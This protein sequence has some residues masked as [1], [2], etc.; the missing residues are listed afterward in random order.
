[1]YNDYGPIEFDCTTC[2]A[3]PGIEEAI[4]IGKTSIGF[5]K[6]GEEVAYRSSALEICVD[7]WQ[8]HT[9]PKR[10]KIAFASLKYPDGSIGNYGYAG[11]DEWN[12]YPRSIRYAW[13]RKLIY[14]RVDF[15]ENLA[16]GDILVIRDILLYNKLIDFYTKNEKNEWEL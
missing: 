6:I 1:M 5:D 12:K 14:V 4:G 9:N 16:Y 3:D 7:V 10:D 13:P 8:M 15:E 2:T 11:K